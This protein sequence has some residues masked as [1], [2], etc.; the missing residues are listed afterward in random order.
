MQLS[1]LG[2]EIE[3]LRSG[4]GVVE[5]WPAPPLNVKGTKESAKSC[6]LLLSLTFTHRWF[7]LSAANLNT[8]CNVTKLYYRLNDKAKY[9]KTITQLYFIRHLK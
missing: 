5:K 1:D 9:Y 3:D 8:T 4:G 6:L 7:L 2:N